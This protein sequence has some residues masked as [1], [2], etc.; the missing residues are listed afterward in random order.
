MQEIFKK[1]IKF[2]GVHFWS[3]KLNNLKILIMLGFKENW[4]MERECII[5]F[6]QSGWCWTDF[7]TILNYLFAFGFFH[8]RNG[9]D[10]LM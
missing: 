4:P 3:V 7:G 8:H 1:F 6:V 5:T 10:N 9:T 2:A